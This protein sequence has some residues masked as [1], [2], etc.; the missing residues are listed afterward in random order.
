MREHNN[1]LQLIYRD[2]V[3]SFKDKK[4]TNLRYMKKLSKLDKFI[5]NNIGNNIMSE[6][7]FKKMYNGPKL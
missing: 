2:H 4:K 5:E 3:S 1:T 7:F 6:C